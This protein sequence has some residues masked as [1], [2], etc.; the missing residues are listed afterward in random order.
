MPHLQSMTALPARKL[1]KEQ[2]GVVIVESTEIKIAFKP[3]ALYI[4]N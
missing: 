4:K 3:L 2:V 1:N